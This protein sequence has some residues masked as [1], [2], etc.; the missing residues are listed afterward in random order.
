MQPQLTKPVFW[1]VGRCPESIPDHE[2]GVYIMRYKG[3]PLYR[4][5]A[6][7]INNKAGEARCRTIYK[8]IKECQPGWRG[9]GTLEPFFLFATC[10][11][12][13]SYLGR[14]EVYLQGEMYRNF[15]YLGSSHFT[16]E[17]PEQVLDV[18]NRSMCAL[19]NN[20]DLLNR[21]VV[22]D[23]KSGQIYDRI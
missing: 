8:R 3:K 9:Y 23:H 13:I 6:L 15:T 14:M 18:A 1:S 19:H 2:F 11:D 4:V 17:C 16:A 7:G 10:N 21:I 22:R 12:W 5:G 20:L